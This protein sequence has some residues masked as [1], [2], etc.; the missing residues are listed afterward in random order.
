MARPLSPDYDKRK[1][2]ILQH[3]A[4]LF[5]AVGY[6]KASIDQL[7]EASTITKSLIYHYFNSKQ[8]IL[9]QCMLSHVELLRSTARGSID[10]N[11]SSEDQ[12]QSILLQ[13]LQIYETAGAR[14]RILV[15]DL[16]QLLP[17]QKSEIVAIEND[18]AQIFKTLI[19][20]ITGSGDKD[21]N[22][23]TARTFLLLSMINW[24]H[25]WFKAGGTMTSEELGKLVY[26]VFV[27]GVAHGTRSEPKKSL[28]NAVKQ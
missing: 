27:N 10:P 6:H 5:A 2:N 15:N 23:D 20:Q 11:K 14:H 4:E 3:S 26:D 13:F 28:P 17:E 16:Q 12:L 1:E 22:L 25:T 24:T 19:T 18:I 21:R 9:Y 8:D 7:A